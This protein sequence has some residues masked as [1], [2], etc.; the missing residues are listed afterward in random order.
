M[1]SQSNIQRRAFLA[2]S[3][4]VA[5]AGWLA[6][7]LPWVAALASCARDDARTGAA[8]THL[9]TAEGRAMRAFAAQ[10]LPSDDKMPGADEA[11][12]VH[13]VDRAVGTPFF[14]NLVPVVRGGLA[15]LD[16]HARAAGGRDG[17]ASLSSAQQVALMRQIE[18]TP[19]FAA[20]RTLVVI[21]T[22]ADPSYGG[23][24]G[25]AGWAIVGMEHRPS[26]AAPF[27]WYDAQV[28]T[29]T[30]TGVS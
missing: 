23:N 30:P 28:D 16:E 7:Q 21:G 25:G 24:R 15:T 13:F 3:T 22:F 26:F 2:E 18:A 10:V 11:G 4:R 5:T 27:G 14:A 12:A 19:F 17:F 8:F 9:T 6:L 29:D 1:R 20:A